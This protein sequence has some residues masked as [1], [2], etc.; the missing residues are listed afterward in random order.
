MSELNKDTFIGFF[1]GEIGKKYVKQVLDGSDFIVIDLDEVKLWNKARANETIEHSKAG[2]K[3]INSALKYVAQQEKQ[4][5]NIPEFE[6]GF[7]GSIIPQ[8]KIHDISASNVGKLVRVRGLVSRTHFIKPMATK[9][10]FICSNCAADNY[11]NALETRQTVKQRNPFTLST[12]SKRCNQCK[13]IVRWSVV[14][15]LSEYVDSQEFSVQENHEDS[16]GRIP[17]LIQMIVTKKHLINKVYCGNSVEITGIIKLVPTYRFKSPSLF[18]IPYIEVYDIIKYSKDPEDIEITQ[19]EEQQIMALSQE[20]NIYK[21]LVENIA[22]SIYGMEKC[23]EGALLSIVGGV[24]KPKGDITIRGN[25]HTLFVGDA[26]MGKSQILESSTGLPPKGIFGVGRGTSGAGLTAALS[27]DE[28]TGDWVIEA[29]TL[30]LADNGLATIDEIDKM[31]END[32]M[33]IHEAMEQQTVTIHK[34]G[35]HVSLRARTA[36]LAAANPTLGKYD[37]SKSVFENLKFPPTLFSRFDLIFVVIDNPSKEDLDDKVATQILSCKVEESTL[38]R[39]LLK[40]YLAYAKSIKP[41]I[42]HEAEKILKDYFLDI[43]KSMQSKEEKFPI[44]YRQLEGLRRIA[45]AH[46]RILLKSE[47]DVSDAEAAKRIFGEYLRDI[48]FDIV[49][50]ETGIPKNMREMKTVI[51]ESLTKLQ[52]MFPNG[53]PFSVWINDLCEQ[54]IP[55]DKARSIIYNDMLNNSQI[56]EDHREGKETYFKRTI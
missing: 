23:K 43:R 3:F 10:V 34:G 40:K 27:K 21:R 36:V 2:A 55:K 16:C 32:R 9:V 35:R 44:T 7:K 39:E 47:V 56:L 6:I 37:D 41:C 8:V 45:E 46:A 54:G 52:L 14:E 33:H 42:S 11:D 48:K 20:P 13:E 49:G 17:Q 5:G 15:E 31:N 51:E 53:V 22:P 1:E 28:A 24:P 29:G 18:Y 26:G 30:V 50:Q 19:E 12:P 4:I 25:I 38:D